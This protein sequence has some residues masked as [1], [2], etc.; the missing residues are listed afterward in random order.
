MLSSAEPLLLSLRRDIQKRS[1]QV[2]NSRVK[3]ERIGEN[4]HRGHFISRAH[5]QLTSLLAA[6]PAQIGNASKSRSAMFRQACKCGTIGGV[7]YRF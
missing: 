1:K 4:V 7:C 5:Q 3:V 6:E 2:F